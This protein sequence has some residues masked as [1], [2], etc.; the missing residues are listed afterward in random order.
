M[1]R[2]VVISKSYYL[3]TYTK[4]QEMLHHFSF[5]HSDYI[6]WTNA[7]LK[8]IKR[9]QEEQLL[10]DVFT[11]IP[12][13]VCGVDSTFLPCVWQVG[14]ALKSISPNTICIFSVYMCSVNCTFS[15]I[16]HFTNVY[17]NAGQ[18]KGCVCVCLWCVQRSRSGCGSAAAVWRSFPAAEW[19][20]SSGRNTR[21][22]SPRATPTPTSSKSLC[23]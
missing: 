20:T 11:L 3:L 21:T 4:L 12:G 6:C 7:F 18:F 17:E 2:Y 9:C 16:W 22:S 13:D 10:E 19:V 15:T 23:I 5:W 1:M 14:Y 8:L